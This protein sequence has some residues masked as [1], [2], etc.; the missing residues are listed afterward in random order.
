[1]SSRDCAC[2]Y[3]LQVLYQMEKK[4][5]RKSQNES[6]STKDNYKSSANF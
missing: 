4:R 5:H 1:M 3:N 6:K 2:F